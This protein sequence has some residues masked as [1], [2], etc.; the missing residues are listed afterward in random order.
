MK[1]CVLEL[2]IMQLLFIA[3]TMMQP[4]QQSKARSIARIFDN[5]LDGHKELIVGSQTE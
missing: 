5:Y 2:L 1:P 4:V 3:P